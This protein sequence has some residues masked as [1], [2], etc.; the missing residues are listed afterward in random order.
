[1]NIAKQRNLLGK[2]IGNSNESDSIKR[3]KYTQLFQKL[4]G[5]IERYKDSLAQADANSVV[6][7]LLYHQSLQLLKYDEID[8]IL[9]KIYPSIS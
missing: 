8:R 9:S 5:E 2:E 3:V 6:P 7:L 4:E 1:M